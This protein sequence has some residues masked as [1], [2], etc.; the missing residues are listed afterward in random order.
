MQKKNKKKKNRKNTWKIISSE[1][2]AVW[3]WN[4]VLM[5]IVLAFTDF[6]LLFFFFFWK[7][8]L[9]FSCRG[10]IGFPLIY[11]RE[12]WKTKFIAKLLQIFWKKTFI[13]MILEKFCFSHIFSPLLVC[14]GCHGNHNAK[15][16][17]KK[18]LKNYLLRNHTLCESET[19][20]KYPSDKPLQI[21]CYLWKSAL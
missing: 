2:Y 14:T 17:K 16:R 19:F 3:S 20:K 6:M 18:I 10:N 13:E 8:P 15:K 12:S 11:N 4:F 21:L 5:F 7:L 1:T 9:W